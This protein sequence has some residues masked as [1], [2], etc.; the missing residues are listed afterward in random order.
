MSVLD[1]EMSV[2]HHNY[3]ASGHSSRHPRF[4]TR[5]HTSNNP[6]RRRPRNP[7]GAC[8]YSLCA[9]RFSSAAAGTR[10]YAG[11]QL[12]TP[13]ALRPPPGMLHGALRENSWGLELDM[14]LCG[15]HLTGRDDYL[16]WY[17]QPW[18]RSSVDPQ[19]TNS[20]PS[21]YIRNYGGSHRWI[22]KLVIFALLL[23]WAEPSVKAQPLMYQRQ[24]QRGCICSSA[25]P[26]WIS[27][28][29]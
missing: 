27:Y 9:A 2:L 22:R 23:V 25:V 5:W 6:S 7:D 19:F 24:R 14:V 18:A 4:S 16:P 21:V 10:A 26:P 15:V 8:R 3:G 1:R 12:P 28:L 29:N 17:P 20:L 13:H 11:V